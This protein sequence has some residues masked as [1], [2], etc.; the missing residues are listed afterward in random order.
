MTAFNKSYLLTLAFVFGNEE[1]RAKTK[2]IN[3][4]LTFL[5]KMKKTILIGLAMACFTMSYAQKQFFKAEKMVET[6]VYYYPE[7]WNPEQWDRDF[8]KMADMG[9]EFT[10][11]AEFA[12]AQIEPTEGVYDFKWLDKALELAAKHNL[13]V[14]MCTPSAT[15]PVWLTRKYPE[16]MVEMPNGQ[17]AQH[18]TREQYSWSSPKYRELTTKV[19]EAMAKHY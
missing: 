9:F 12:W 14:I 13:K 2:D 18:G 3:L 11:M 6:G 10:H 8:K 1:Q 17:T 4:S 5:Y 16:V 15:P 7:A 19:V